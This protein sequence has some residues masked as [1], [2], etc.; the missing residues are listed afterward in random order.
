MFKEGLGTH[1]NHRQNTGDSIMNN[2][3][4]LDSFLDEVTESEEEKQAI[5]D[6]CSVSLIDSSEEPVNVHSLTIGN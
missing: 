2:L 1:P 5:K 3:E 4:E 6:L